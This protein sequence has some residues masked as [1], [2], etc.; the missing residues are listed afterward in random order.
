MPDM[1]RL[2][3]IRRPDGI[4]GKQALDAGDAERLQIAACRSQLVEMR[5]AFQ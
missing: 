2:S 5:I 3:S 4:R 1:V